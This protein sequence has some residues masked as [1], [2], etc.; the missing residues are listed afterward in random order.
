ML[1]DNL[2]FGDQTPQI[3]KKTLDALSLRQVLVS[4][5]ISN[6]DTP[7]Y[8]A[9]D[10]DFASQLSEVMNSGNNLALTATHSRHIGHSGSDV[11]S[12]EFEVFE[13]SAPARADGNNVD[14]DKEMMKLAENQ[15]RYNAAVQL[16]TKRT[17]TILAA[18]NESAQSR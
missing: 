4:S 18:I 16:L 6:I 11:D 2:L 14:L 15:I 9:K 8:K 3:L 13:E 12:V 10:I 1:I 7:G 17:S 5:N